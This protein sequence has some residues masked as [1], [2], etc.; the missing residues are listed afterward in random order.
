MVFEI[1]SPYLKGFHLTLASSLPKRDDGGWKLSD[2]EWYGYVEAKLED[3]SITEEQAKEMRDF[4]EKEMP[5]PPE[6]ILPVES[7]GMSIKA[8]ETFMDSDLPPCVVVRQCK[9]TLLIYGFVDASGSGFGSSKLYKNNLYYR[10]GI[11][12]TKD[13]DESSNWREFENLVEDFEEQGRQGWLEGS[14][15]IMATDNDTVEKV[16]YKGN[17]SDE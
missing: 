9:A 13:S 16:I 12:S 14:Y 10:I 8:L 17:S 1:F 4:Q 3:G 11:C 7:F 5:P 15:V 2:T 6:E